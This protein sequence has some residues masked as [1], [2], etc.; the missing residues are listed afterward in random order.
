MVWVQQLQQKERTPNL[1]PQKFFDFFRHY[2][3]ENNW[4]SKSIKLIGRWIAGACV[5]TLAF[6]CRWY[7]TPYNGKSTLNHNLREYFWSFWTKHRG[8]ANPRTLRCAD[9]NLEVVDP[10]PSLSPQHILYIYIYTSFQQPPTCLQ[11]LQATL[12]KALLN[13]QGSFQD[14][15]LWAKKLPPKL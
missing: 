13:R 9:P 12:F 1:H 6:V 5:Q 2:F 14:P 4:H 10:N 8:Q 3:L 7:F 11:T 15:H